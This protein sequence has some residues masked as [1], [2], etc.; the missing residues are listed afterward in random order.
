MHNFAKLAAFSLFTAGCCAAQQ[1]PAETNTII[2]SGT[3]EVLLEVSVHDK[4]GKS[5]KALKPTDFTVYED[6][7]PRP[8]QSFRLIAGSEIRAAEATQQQQQQSQPQTASSSPK[9]AINSLKTVNLLCLVFGH[10]QVRTRATAFKAAQKFTESELRPNTFI[11]TFVMSHGSVRQ[12][13]NFTNNRDQLLNSLKQLEKNPAGVVSGLA[14]GTPPQ[15]NASSFSDGP[16]LVV[17]GGDSAP[18]AS[19]PFGDRGEIDYQSTQALNDIDTLNSLVAGLAPLPYRK[20]VVLFIGDLPRSADS[21]DDWSAL[22]DRARKASVTFYGWSTIEPSADYDPLDAGR[23]ALNT[24]AGISSNIPT[25]Q[26]DQLSG[27]PSTPNAGSAAP[28]PGSSGAAFD[29]MRKN[30][31]TRYAATGSNW[32]EAANDLTSATG[33]FFISN[34]NNT[35]LLKKIMDE[36]DTRY[37]VSFRPDT[38]ILDGRYHKIEVKLNRP[39]YHAETRNGYFAVPDE[40]SLT[41]ADIAGLRA[42]S[43]SPAP[44]AFDFDSKAFWFRKKTAN[45]EQQYAVVFDVPVSHLT[46]TPEPKLKRHKFHAVLF[47]VAKNAQGEIVSRFGKDVESEVSDDALSRLESDR[48]TFEHPFLLP[49]DATTVETVVVDEEGHRS[50]A[51]SFTLKTPQANPDSPAMSDI[52]L[53]KRIDDLKAPADPTDPFQFDGK[54]LVPSLSQNITPNQKLTAFLYTYPSKSNAYK[55]ALNVRSERDGKLLSNQT[56]S[57]L[58]VP[59]DQGRIQIRLGVT[60]LPGTYKLTMKAIQ[61][62]QSVERVLSYSVSAN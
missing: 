21:S 47:A 41:P 23:I 36:V 24:A 58:P 19:N 39:D 59:D 60:A 30:D 50:S 44:H 43:D 7:I 27:P 46:A 51:N 45:G 53:A 54:R 15:S 20:S 57:E 12:L 28:T 62:D 9:P 42:L 34:T 31:F 10:L 49:A 61:G 37:E 52:V 55:M 22:I 4:R 33:G 26:A 5:V 2:R 32:Q 17:Q 56:I 35:D 29:S 8:V 40:E 13:T 14:V 11:A 38:D 18:G 3:R 16:P 6:G 48:V 25:G 1:T